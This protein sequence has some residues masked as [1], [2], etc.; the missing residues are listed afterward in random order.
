MTAS[1]L[2]PD[3]TGPFEDDVVIS[4]IDDEEVFRKR[5]GVFAWTDEQMQT[6]RWYGWFESERLA[7]DWATHLR[8]EGCYVEIAVAYDGSELK[9]T[10]PPPSRIWQW[11]KD[12][13]ANIIIGLVVLLML[14]GILAK[15]HNEL[16][17]FFT[18]NLCG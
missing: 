16:T 3:A 2:N 6:E 10:V 18:G 17:C 7:N 5:I 1:R 8:K 11:V 4:D 13:A 15:A 12:A 14:G 9:T